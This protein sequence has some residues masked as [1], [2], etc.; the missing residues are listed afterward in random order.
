MDLST[1]IRRVPAATAPL[2]TLATISTDITRPIS[3]NATMNGTHGAI[4]PGRAQLGGQVGL[5]AEQRAARQR[6]ADPR[7]VGVHLGGRPGAGR[8][9]RASGWPGGRAGRAASAARPGST[10]ASA[11]PVTEEARPTTVSLGE[12][13]AP[14]TVSVAPSSG[15]GP[16]RSRSSTISPGCARPAARGDGQVVDRAAGRGAA[17]HGQR[18]H[19]HALLAGPGATRL[20]RW[21]RSP[22]SRR[23]ARPRR[24]PRTAG[25]RRPAG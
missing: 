1:P 10:Q 24:S 9:G 17:D 6:G 14:S 18:G 13:G 3:P 8:T 25:R 20:S 7:D 5:R 2:T 15:A 23:T 11:V 19:H 4:E 12:P 16:R 22:W 21:S